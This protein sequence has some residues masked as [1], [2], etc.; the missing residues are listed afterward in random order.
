M[1]LREVNMSNFICKWLP[2]LI[3]NTS[4][5][6]WKEFADYCYSLF[7]RDFIDTKPLFLGKSV[8]IRKHPL[9]EDK[10]Q[11]FSHCTSFDPTKK[12][13][14]PNDRIDD[15]KRY[16]RIEWPRKI[17]ENYSCSD[18]C[19]CNHIKMWR[20]P[21][22]SYDRVHLLFQDVKYLVIIEERETYN[23]LVS[24]FYFHYDH[25]LDKKLK[26]YERYK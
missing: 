9:Q 5:E 25:Q 18:H 7:K 8:N 16:E 20:E 4:F 1:R 15:I 14:D 10:E 6:D 21:W 24:A 11:G 12:S 22:K 23:L 13:A 2:P 17:I 3:S 26:K 19:E